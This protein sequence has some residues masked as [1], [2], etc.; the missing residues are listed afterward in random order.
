[1]LNW[2]ETEKSDFLP[3]QLQLVKIVMLELNKKNIYNRDFFESFSTVKIYAFRKEA[4]WM[5]ILLKNSQSKF[6]LGERWYNFLAPK[7]YNG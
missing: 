1:M 5:Q 2:T 3:P 7:S 6:T 4:M